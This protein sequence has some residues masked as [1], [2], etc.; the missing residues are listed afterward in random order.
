MIKR[1]LRC[2]L[3]GGVTRMN[4]SDKMMCLDLPTI[5]VNFGK[6]YSSCPRFGAFSFKLFEILLWEVAIDQLQTR[7]NGL[8]CQRILIG[9]IK[10]LIGTWPLSDPMLPHHFPQ[11]RCRV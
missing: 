4:H 7:D 6:P 9:N 10:D 5:A 8:K 2:D 1:N 11:K 3:N